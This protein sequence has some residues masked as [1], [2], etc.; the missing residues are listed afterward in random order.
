MFDKD[1]DKSITL[2]ELIEALPGKHL[3]SQLEQIFKEADV[4]DD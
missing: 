2:S 1:G 4:D 3:L